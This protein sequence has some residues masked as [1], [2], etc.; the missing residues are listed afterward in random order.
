MTPR[1]TTASPTP[2]ISPTPSPTPSAAESCRYAQPDPHRPE[3][4]LD[5]EVHG[6][7][8]RGHE[9]LRF[10]PDLP[11]SELVLRLWAAA[12]RVARAGGSTS[13]RSVRVEGRS[14]SFTRPSA[15]MIRIPWR[16]A[17]G[18]TV[19]LDLDFDVI[20][21]VGADDRLGARGR[22]SWFGSGFPLLAWE[23][24]RGWATEPATS[25]F[26]EASTSEAMRLVRL[27]V[28][29][30]PGLSVLATGELVT[31]DAGRTVTRA[32]AVR[33]VAVAVGAFRMA[34]VKGPVPVVVG[35]DPS[36]PDDPSAV[37][38]ELAR[39]LKAHAARF[40][41]YPFGRLAAAVI[42]DLRGGIEYPGAV[43]L[44]TRQDR[45]ATASH[46]VAHQWFYGLVGDDQARDPWLDEA[47]ATYAEALDRGTAARY[48]RATIPADGVGRTGRP[49]TY[50]EGRSSYFRSVYLQGA[51]AL[52]DARRLHPREFD[53][54]VRCYVAASAYRIATPTDVARSI[55]LAVPALRRVGALVRD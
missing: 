35:V 25:A 10:T 6:R 40:G 47:F 30:D 36:L 33:D 7:Q 22:T 19:T 23:R 55:P 52:L 15:T 20:L 14:H 31:E 28:R 2:T 4:T 53:A 54:Q 12:P 37:A 3:L 29:H 16:A 9:Q 1:T 27:S 50:W 8:V 18:T 48:R 17:A 32:A 42:P 11:I 49:M 41:P 34:A 39:A 38:A 43:L 5:L 24:G 51:V 26:A 46:E 44:G 21:P 45:D 13:L